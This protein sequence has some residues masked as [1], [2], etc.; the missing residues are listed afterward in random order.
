VCIFVVVCLFLS[1]SDCIAQSGLKLEILLPQP[2][3]CWD[4]RRA[5]PPLFVCLFVLTK[6][7]VKFIRKET[8]LQ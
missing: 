5:P 8:H 6:V 2:P 3:K 1:D 7:I 4:Y